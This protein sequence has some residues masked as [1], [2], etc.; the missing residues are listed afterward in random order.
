MLHSYSLHK[1]T[2]DS[3]F[4]FDPK[5]YSL[6]KFGD[7]DVA[8]KFGTQL[9]KGFIQNVLQ[10]QPISSQ[11]VVISSPYAF[12]P[13]A[14]F[15]LKNHFIFELNKYLVQNNFPVVQETKVD[16][17]VT[18]REDYGGLSAEERMKLISNDHFHIDAS[19]CLNKTLLFL[20][21]IRITGSHERMI[22]RMLQEFD[23]KNAGYLLY[24]AEL[25]NMN[26]DPKIENYFNF[27]AVKSIFD[28][29]AI[30]KNKNFVINTRIVKYILNSTSEEF[31]EFAQ[32]QDLT[33]LKTI[34]NQAVGNSY[35]SIDGYKENMI[36]LANLVANKQR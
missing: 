21:D 4:D 31:N 7:G 17:T 19:Y 28:L 32:Q 35:F 5:E 33:I 22:N 9:A 27:S 36:A 12:I 34:Y 13:T 30:V 24:F 11:I 6:F 16:R 26:I 2:T 8:C 23:L 18:Y 20:D 25:T 10:K 29:T 15:A 1:I 3:N 14:T